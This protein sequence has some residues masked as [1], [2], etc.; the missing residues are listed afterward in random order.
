M[1]KS[2]A[3]PLATDKFHLI[4]FS[5]AGEIGRAS[6]ALLRYLSPLRL[7]RDM[8]LAIRLSFEEALANAIFHGNGNSPDKKVEIEAECSQGKSAASG[9]K[10]LKL[11]VKDEGAGF[12]YR[13]F[14]KEIK[15]ARLNRPRRRGLLLISNLMDRVTFNPKGN[16]IRITKYLP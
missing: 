12:D 6:R 10:C 7:D 4:I 15:R 5:S 3:K 9:K 13:G 16:C 1:K 14:F 8:K 11:S 2:C